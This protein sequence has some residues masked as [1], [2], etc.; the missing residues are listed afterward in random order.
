MD[1]LNNYNTD[2]TFGSDSTAGSNSAD[3]ASSEPMQELEAE[4]ISEDI[5]SA[6]DSIQEY[7]AEEAGTET[8]VSYQSAPEYTADNYSTE[9]TGYQYTPQQT[10]G[11]NSGEYH[12]VRP[13]AGKSFDT[14]ESV[15]SSYNTFKYNNPYVSSETPVYSHDF[16][17]EKKTVRKRKQMGRGWLVAL[18]IILSLA[19]GFGGAWTYSKFFAKEPVVIT[20]VAETPETTTAPVSGVTDLSQVVA[21]AKECVV[22]ITTETMTTGNFF[23]Q[24]I[25]T[26]AGSGVIIDS[27]GYIAT[28]YH[29]IQGA[30]TISVIL[31]DGSTYS[32]KVVGYDSGNDIAVVKIDA[33]GLS[34]AA[35]A[36]SSQLKVGETVFA[37]GNPLGSLGGTVTDGIVSAL[38]REIEVEGQEMTLLQTSAAVNHGNSGGGLFNAKGE[39]IG[40]VNAKSSGEDVEGLGFAI[41]SNVA[42]QVITDIINGGG[43]YNISTPVMGVTV[44]DIYDEQT[45]QEYGVS[46]YGIYIIEVQA[47]Y[48]AASAGLEKGDCIVS[49]DNI[50]VARVADLTSM[51]KKYSVG[52]VIEVTVVRGNR[53]MS[54]DVE[55]KSR[56]TA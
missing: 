49:V 31:P 54:F 16:T 8:P 13:D 56:E 24:S 39:L 36:D 40:I 20:T 47:G 18:C 1:D 27:D 45:A 23:S 43:T 9:D 34:S 19:S 5:Q 3:A 35:F 37:I 2:N 29:V 41:P 14:P 50:A 26:G 30:S 12:Y 46:R 6:A 51:L 52:D 38:D 17:A 33:S 28:C 42:K 10:A 48:G 11:A 22:E 55:L 7:P 53:L 15:N 32:G 44:M 4:T 25:A 21:A